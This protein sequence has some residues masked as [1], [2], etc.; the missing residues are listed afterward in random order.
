M[1]ASRA[2][3]RVGGEN[4]VAIRAEAE[5]GGSSPRRRG[6]RWLWRGSGAPWG[7]IPA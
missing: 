7:L 3:P 1:T 5:Y 2:H 4:L 6:K